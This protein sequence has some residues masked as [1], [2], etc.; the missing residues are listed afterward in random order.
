MTDQH[1]QFTT[2]ADGRPAVRFTGRF[3]FLARLAYRA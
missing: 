1:I 2:L 3:L